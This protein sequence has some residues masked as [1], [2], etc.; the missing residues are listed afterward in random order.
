MINLIEELADLM[1]ER[2]NTA[3]SYPREWGEDAIHQWSAEKIDFYL[4]EGTK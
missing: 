2:V 1:Q 3:V 4:K